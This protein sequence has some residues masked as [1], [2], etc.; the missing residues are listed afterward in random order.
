MNVLHPQMALIDYEVRGLRLD[1]RR[2]WQIVIADNRM[3]NKNSEADST[4]TAVQSEI[5]VR[6]G[7]F[8]TEK[9]MQRFVSILPALTTEIHGKGNSIMAIDMRYP[10]GFAVQT[11]ETENNDK[12]V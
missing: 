4:D 6:L 12:K 1:D 8:E 9:R 5:T 11:S 3:V 2:A 7:R 10:N